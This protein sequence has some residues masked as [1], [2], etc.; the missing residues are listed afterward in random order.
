M[1]LCMTT[2]RERHLGGRT[3]VLVDI[4]NVLGG[5]RFDSRQ[6]ARARREIMVLAGIAPEAQVTIATSAD[7]PLLEAHVGWPGARL[8]WRRGKDGADLALADVALNE[9][10]I[11]RF[12]RVV[13]AS[14]DGIF[15]VVATWLQQ[16][17][18]A[19]T[20][21]SRPQAL[22]RALQGRVADVRLLGR[23]EFLGMSA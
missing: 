18:V 8:L 4:E 5:T 21:V 2:Q 22:S 3:A 1:L 12:D 6:V 14:G 15:A 23:P 9:N 20:V 7:L 10:L 19:V 16:H 13:L 11:D 17:G